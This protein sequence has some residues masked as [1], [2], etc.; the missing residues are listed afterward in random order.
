MTGLDTDVSKFFIYLLFIYVTTI[1]ITALYRM[2]ASL[3][4]SIDDA[5][6]FSGISLNILVVLTG[7]VAQQSLVLEDG[8]DS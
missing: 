5:V 6:R 7:Y 1:C 2:M 4:P 3:S 8:T